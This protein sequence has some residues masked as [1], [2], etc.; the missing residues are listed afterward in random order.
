MNKLLI[1]TI[2]V[3]M[4]TS[5]ESV[6]DDLNVNPN[7]FTEVPAQLVLNQTVLNTVSISEAA[8]ARI[9]GMWTDQFAGTDR[10]YIVQDRFEVDAATFDEVWADLYQQG[11]SQAQIAQEL[12]T[13]EG[14]LALTNY[15]QLL[16]GY[17]AAEA[18]LIFG[19]VPYTEVNDL[20]IADPAYDAQE[21]V[22]LNAIALIEGAISGAGAG[23]SVSA[24]NE[25]YTG[26]STWA[27]FGQ[28]LLARYYLAQSD[29]GRALAAA[30]A[31]DFNS[32]TDGIDVIHTTTNFGENLFYQFEAEQREDYLSF[33]RLG[34]TQSTLFNF[35]SDTTNLSRADDKTDDTA[36]FN[37]FIAGVANDLYK[38]NVGSDGFFAP[39]MN[40]PIIG[41]PEVQLIIAEAAARTGEMDQAITALNNARNY[42]DE[43][44]ATDSYMDYDADDFENE[45]TLIRAILIEKY[46]SVFGLPTFYDVIRTDN[47]IGADMDGREAPA[48]RFLYPSTELSSNSKFPFSDEAGGSTITLAS[49]NE[50][51]KN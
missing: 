50:V 27:Q 45:D 20:E 48:Q 42:W 13:A 44:T 18:A 9:A 41:Y 51:L 49:T 8:P 4:A 15:A 28:A 37:F 11:I 5:C 31:A 47:L 33:G 12:A 46:A 38:L 7:E 36:R 24:G 40:F 30:T 6:V 26:T 29:Y 3:A 2:A 14:A 35:L 22:L 1:A 16:E 39:D 21:E 34:T 32:T 10:Q 43:L 25:V 17:Y 23:N 19:D